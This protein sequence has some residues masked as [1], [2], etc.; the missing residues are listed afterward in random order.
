M[1]VVKLPRAFVLLALLLPACAVRAQIP[2]LQDGDIIFQASR[3][4]QSLAIQRATG[5]RYSHM[6]VIF[7][8]DGRPQVFE[9]S[10]TVR[11]TPLKKWIAR[12]QDG[13]FVVKRLKSAKTSLTVEKLVAAR[14]LAG[15]F[16]GKRYDLTF[17]W[18][19]R[20]IYCSELVWKLYNRVLGVKIGKLQRLREFNLDDPAVRKKLKERYGDAV[21]LEE[22]VISPASMFDS[23]LLEEVARN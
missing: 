14:K 3:S 6:G 9:A 1:F 12:G 22:P 16:R 21:P 11:E 23:E 18:S 20:R 2:K 4:A 7:N 10:A 5:S 13:H 17:E 15:S 19:D 8:R